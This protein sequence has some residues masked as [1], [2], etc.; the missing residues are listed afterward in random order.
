MGACICTHPGWDSCCTRADDPVCVA[1]NVACAALKEPISVALGTAREAVNRAKNTLDVAKG[2]LSTAQ[3]AINAAKGTLDIAIGALE[4]VKITYKAGVSALSALTNFALTEII[5]IRGIYFRTT[6]SV[7]Q[8]G[9][10]LCRLKGT[11]MGESIDV[12]LQFDVKNIMGIAK[13]LGERAIS[14]I[15]G[16]IG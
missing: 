4:T 2:A 6:L 10:F 16:F 1:T 12:H 13:S 9:Q 11:L 7:A 8:G 14:G 15:A 3:G 5:N